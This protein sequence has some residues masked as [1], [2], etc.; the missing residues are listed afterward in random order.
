MSSEKSFPRSLSTPLPHRTLTN[1]RVHS[2]VSKQPVIIFLFVCLLGYFLIIHLEY[3]LSEGLSC[4][5]HC[6]LMEHLDSMVQ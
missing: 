2:F 4:L 3:R 1:H 5:S 6:G